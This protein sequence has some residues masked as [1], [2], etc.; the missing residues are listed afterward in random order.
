MTVQKLTEK[1]ISIPSYVDGDVDEVQVAEFLYEYLQ[2]NLPW[3]KVVK[4]YVKGNRY[5]IVALPEKELS[6]LFV[7]HMDTVRP[8]GDPVKRT[9]PKVKD[10]KLYGLGSADMKG[11]LAAS[12]LAAQAAG[13]ESG[14]GLIYDIDE[15]YGFLGAKALIEKYLLKP[16][17]LV[18]PEPTNLQVVNGCRGVI[19]VEIEIRGRGGH[20]ARPEDGLNA[21][22]LSVE[23]LQEVEQ[24]L[25]LLD[26]ENIGV[27]SVNLASLQGGVYRED[28]YVIQ[29]NAIPDYAKMLVDIRPASDVTASDIV[30]MFKSTTIKL[31]GE[32]IASKVNLDYA[33]YAI[34]TRKLEALLPK[35]MRFRGELDK[36]GFYESAIF[37]KAW[38]VPSIN[39][40]PSGI[41]HIEDES[42]DL[43]S[44]QTAYDVYVKMIELVKVN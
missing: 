4:Q 25:R 17:L 32:M 36:S 6:I 34:P 42:V 29:A 33:G 2:K 21:L 14:V 13:S 5:N 10:N 40:G 30:E 19:E 22:L 24:R 15:E 18:C 39:F 28:Q 9:K 12:L 31:G 37:S 35:Q 16:Q 8:I 11:G 1:L 43:R 44:L 38:G 20:A 23:I 3:L 41:G 7:S 26:D 27:T